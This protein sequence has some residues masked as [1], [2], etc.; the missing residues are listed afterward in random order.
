MLVFIPTKSATFSKFLKNLDE[1]V[2]LE[3]ILA[4]L[5]DLTEY[6]A[7][8]LDKKTKAIQRAV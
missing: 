3:D 4:I 2:G 5:A 6:V 7:A 1:C 8:E